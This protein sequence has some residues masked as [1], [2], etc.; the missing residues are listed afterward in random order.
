MQ[1]HPL[2]NCEK[3]ER[4]D[5]LRRAGEIRFAREDEGRAFGERWQDAGLVRILQGRSD[6]E[7]GAGVATPIAMT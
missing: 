6:L 3:K 2:S 1:R 5:R 4:S 7:R